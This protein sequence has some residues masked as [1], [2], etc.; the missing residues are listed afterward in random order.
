MCYHVKFGSSVRK[1]V[2]INRKDPQIWEC[3]DSAGWD[4]DVANHLKQAP[5]CVAQSL[6]ITYYLLATVQVSA[7]WSGQKTG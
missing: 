3:L 6:L 1:G 4:G 2:C 7:E 5:P